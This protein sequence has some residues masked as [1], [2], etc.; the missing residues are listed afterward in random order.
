MVGLTDRLS[1]TIVVGWDVKPTTNQTKQ[2]YKLLTIFK[3]A[4]SFAQYV[5]ESLRRNFAVFLAEKKMV[6]A[7]LLEISQSFLRENSR[8]RIFVRGV[9]A[10]KE[11]FSWSDLYVN[12]KLT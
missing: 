9:N 4:P 6:C 12:N 1:M 7:N 3:M 8:L 11:L 5:R 10:V 2:K